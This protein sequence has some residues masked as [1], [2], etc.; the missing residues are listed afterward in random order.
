MEE[1][2]E[3]LEIYEKWM[4]KK[5]LGPA[6]KEELKEI[7]GNE[8]EI[9]ERFY[10]TIEFGTAGL[11]GILG[12]GTNRMNIYTVR[13]AAQGFAQAINQNGRKDNRVV[14]AYDSRKM[15]VEFSKESA[16]IFASNGI[17]VYLF[18]E[19]TP[20][21]VLSYA[22]RSLKCSGGVMITAS[23]NPKNYNG[24]KVYWDDGAQVTEEK[25]NL[26][27][28]EVNK[29]DN[30]LD[31]ETKSFDEYLKEEKI[32]VIY[33][34]VYAKYYE[35]INNLE[36]M[37]K[38]DKDIS[39]LFSPFFGTSKKAVAHVMK[40]YSFKN[41]SVLEEQGEP[42]SDFPNLD[43]PNPED[44][45]SFMLLREKAKITKPDLL[46]ATDPDGD[47]IGTQVLHNGEYVVLTGNQMG[48]LMVDYL[49][50]KVPVPENGYIVKTVVTADLSGK[51]ASSKGVKVYEVLT[52]F[53]Y[54]AELAKELEP[55][56]EKYIFGYEE[57]Y[58]YM[59]RL[60]VR[61]KDAI[62][63]ILLLAQI[64]S[65]L[66]DIEQTLIDRLEDIYLEYGYHEEINISRNYEGIEGK[67]KM[68]GIM[69][70]LREDFAEKTS[71]ELVKMQDFYY[72]IER[73]FTTKT[74]ISIDFPQSNVLKFYLKDRSWVAVRPSGTEPKIKYY[75]SVAGKDK[76]DA[77][78][79]A[80]KFKEEFFKILE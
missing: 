6:L 64:A 11:R 68:V 38:G 33:D 70:L 45:K 80:E 77:E 62:Q 53:K 4:S 51:I 1:R 60:F 36:Y 52:G 18:S 49:M 63:A 58:G 28:N 73:D 9:E 19:V 21:P 56:G 34:E 43:Y 79:K 71:L 44:P 20:T 7:E 57:S 2:K 22:V 67:E 46:M 8:D 16:K 76:N 40:Q 31:L 17:K 47:R 61:D 27:I 55:K 32:Q 13:R 59:P 29:V 26:I 25:A 37:K 66:K 39:I 14:L 24:Y 48:V 30:Y 72:S 54:I 15:S 12:A 69:N 10:Q 65:D 78:M 3:Y 75:F 35:E 41:F 74:E 23:H 42:N 5:D 50:N